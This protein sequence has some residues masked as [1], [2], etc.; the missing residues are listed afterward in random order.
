MPVP[1]PPLS[2]FHHVPETK[3]DL[4]W[5]DLPTVD[6]ALYG[7]PEGRKLLAKILIDAVK[8]KGFLYVKGFDISQERVD[9]QFAIGQKFYELPL[10]EKEKYVPN[11]EI[12]EY[13]GYRPAGRRILDPASGLTDRN[14]VYNIPKFNGDFKQEHPSPVSTHLAEIEEFARDLH[15]HVLDPLLV[16]FALALELPEDY[17]TKIHTYE[18]KSEDHLRYMKY[19]KYTP[20]ENKRIKGVWLKGHTDLGSVTLL[21]RQP[22]ASLQI[23]DQTTEQWKW[24]KPQ[25]GTITVNTCDALSF[26]TGGYIK[27]TIHRV[28]SPPKDQQHVDRL[29]LLYFARPHNDVVLNTI[30]ES[31]VLQREGFTQ[32]QFEKIGKVPT[33]EEFTFSKQTWQQSSAGYVDGAT[34]LPGFNEKLYD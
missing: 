3:E 34:I 32:N 21:F 27:S 22:V 24:V 8:T 12:G 7:T 18:K 9:R 23:R 17:L 15:K 20:E 29:G 10:E 2:S 11:L 30:K 6:L 16:L 19:S 13:N 5:A 1:D 14:E 26:L 28:V 25:D 4:D 33:M 31:P